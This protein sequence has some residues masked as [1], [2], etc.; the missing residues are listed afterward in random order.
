MFNGDMMRRAT[1]MGEKVTKGTFLDSVV[2]NSRLSPEQRISYL[3][4]A[5]LARMPNNAEKTELARDVATRR[6]S[7]DKYQDL[8]WAILNSNEFI[9]NH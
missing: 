1:G 4:L 3:Y 5:G 6:D 9:L 2:N 8:W 7:I